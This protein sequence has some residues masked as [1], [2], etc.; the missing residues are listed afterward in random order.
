MTSFI[1]CTLHQIFLHDQIKENEMGGDVACMGEMRNE[2]NIL[3]RKSDGKRPFG[4][5]K[6]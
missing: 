4:R 6:H 2:Y 1:T 5:P 3:I